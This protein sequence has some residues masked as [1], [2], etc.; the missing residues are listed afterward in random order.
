MYNIKRVGFSM[1][2]LCKDFNLQ[3][4]KVSKTGVTTT[5]KLNEHLSWSIRKIVTFDKFIKL[6]LGIFCQNKN[7][8]Q[9]Y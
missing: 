9:N 5:L 4:I 1:L 6:L 2:S 8:N 3:P 7:I